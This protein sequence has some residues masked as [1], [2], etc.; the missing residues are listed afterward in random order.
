MMALR[1]TFLV[2]V[3]EPRVAINLESNVAL[4]N[5]HLKGKPVYWNVP[6]C[7]NAMLARCE[8]CKLM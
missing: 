1:L 8:D 6:D 5:A 7:S 4:G 2:T 3:R